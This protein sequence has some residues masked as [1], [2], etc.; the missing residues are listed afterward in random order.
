MAFPGE[1]TMFTCASCISAN[2]AKREL[3]EIWSCIACCIAWMDLPMN[4]ATTSSRF[5]SSLLKTSLC[6]HTLTTPITLVL[7]SIGEEIKLLRGS[8]ARRARLAN[9]DF[10]I[11][12]ISKDWPVATTCPAIPSPFPID[13]FICNSWQHAVASANSHMRVFR[14][15]I[16]KQHDWAIVS[17]KDFGCHFRKL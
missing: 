12:S 10:F 15:R 3:R 14:L 1:F 2:W 9:P 5:R 16:A 13:Y 6:P 4:R 11:S 17:I 7:T 8:L